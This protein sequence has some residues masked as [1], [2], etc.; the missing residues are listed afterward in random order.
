[1]LNKLILFSISI[2]SFATLN[3][4]VILD[5]VKIV[6]IIVSWVHRNELNIFL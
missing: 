1:M 4:K 2:K 6:I 5:V 3:V